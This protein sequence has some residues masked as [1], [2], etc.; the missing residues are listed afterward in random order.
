MRSGINRFGAYRYICPDGIGGVAMTKYLLIACAVLGAVCAF[1]YN[2]YDN[3]GKEIARLETANNALQIN[4]ERLVKNENEY[5]IQIKTL[6]EEIAK[7]KSG[8]DWGYNLANNP[9]RLLV[10][11]ECLSCD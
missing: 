11:K 10:S 6:K 3:R 4:S 8:F 2:G 1:L 5:R 7:D 9:V